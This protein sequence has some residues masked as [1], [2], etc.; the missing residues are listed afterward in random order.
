MPARLAWVLLATPLATAAA[1]QPSTYPGC[2]TRTLEVPWGGAATVD[3]RDCQAF[4]LGDV[5]QAPAHGQA[6]AGDVEPVESYTYS[7]AGAS[8]AGGGA[9]RFVV[10]D[11]NGDAITVT[12]AIAPPGAGAATIATALPRLRAGAALEQPLRAEGLRAPLRWTLAGGALPAGLALDAAGRLHG[13]PTAR[14]P[15]AFTLEV[16]DAAGR[17]DRGSFAGTVEPGDLQLRPDRAD[18]TPGVAFSVA[19]SASGGVPPYRFQAE[20]RAGLPAGVSLSPQGLLSGL[21]AGPAGAYRLAVR[22]A[23]ASTGPGEHFQVRTFTLV[24][25]RVPTVTITAPVAAIAEDEP[26]GLAFVVARDA[27]LDTPT[28][29]LL[30]AGG[31]AGLAGDRGGSWRVRIPAGARE[32]RVIVRPRPDDRPEPDETVEFTLVPASGYL[33]GQPGRASGTLV[34]DDAP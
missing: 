5:A 17:V 28:E 34:D 4:G 24:L 31:S 1:G 29:V 12:V 18:V 33:V 19:L 30:R 8:P 14:G 15:F 27:A 20:S 6:T 11:D 32:A 23:D 22:V 16:R 3:L 25:G 9:D 21:N 2:A 26:Q 7:H 13:T 10:L